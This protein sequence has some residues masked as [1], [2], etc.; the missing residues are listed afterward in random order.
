MK[1]WEARDVLCRL[2]KPKYEHIALDQRADSFPPAD[3]IKNWIAANDFKH[4]ALSI[5][6]TCLNEVLGSLLSFSHQ[7]CQ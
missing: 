5:T 7:V 2:P 6:E 4:T 3:I 1:I